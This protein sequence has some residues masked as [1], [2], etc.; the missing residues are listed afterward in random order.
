MFK[1]MAIFGNVTYYCERVDVGLDSAI[2][3]GLLF[4]TSAAP[5]DS[6]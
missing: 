4:T 2:K 6:R 5:T 1:A 3:Q